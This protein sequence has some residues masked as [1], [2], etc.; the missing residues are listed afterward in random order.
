MNIH[1]YQAKATDD[2]ANEMM[3]AMKVEPL[4]DGEGNARVDDSGKPRITSYNVCYTKLL[5]FTGPM[6]IYNQDIPPGFSQVADTV[7]TQT[8]NFI[9]PQG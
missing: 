4:V 8:R 2:V 9:T 6:T 3:D 7:I 1:E 5:R